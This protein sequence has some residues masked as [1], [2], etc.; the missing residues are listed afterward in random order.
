MINKQ[1]LPLY[2]DLLDN[3]MHLKQD[4]KLEGVSV[5][6]RGVSL[7]KQVEQQRSEGRITGEQYRELIITI[8]R[9]IRGCYPYL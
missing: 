6:A 7:Y 4:G 5:N 9:Q 1:E 2:P 3:A 8:S